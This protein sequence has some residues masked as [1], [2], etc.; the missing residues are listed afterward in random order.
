MDK[1]TFTQTMADN[2]RLLHENKSLRNTNNELAKENVL[3]HKR[4]RELKDYIDE[5]EMYFKKA[6]RI[7]D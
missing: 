3:L 5:L 1:N 7:G 2:I 4:A 6:D